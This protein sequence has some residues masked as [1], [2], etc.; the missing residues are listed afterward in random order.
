MNVPHKSLHRSFGTRTCAC[1][2][3]TPFESTHWKQKY[4]HPSHALKVQRAKD[5]ARKPKLNRDKSSAA[6]KARRQYHLERMTTVR[7]VDGIQLAPGEDLCERAAC[8]AIYHPTDPRQRYCGGDCR[9][10]NTNELLP[11]ALPRERAAHDKRLQLSRQTLGLA[12]VP[13]DDRQPFGAPC[14]QGLA[15]DEGLDGK[16]PWAHV[17]SGADPLPA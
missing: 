2:C 4:A 8:R 7:V 13:Y 14:A 16:I 17:W 1:G 10:K 12:T 15:L 11:K 9:M 3:G 5:N 6:V